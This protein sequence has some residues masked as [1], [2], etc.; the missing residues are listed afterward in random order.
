MAYPILAPNSTWFAPTVSTVTRSMITEI[1]IMDSFS[2]AKC[3][4][5]SITEQNISV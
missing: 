4:L 1:E 3:H 2:G 5:I